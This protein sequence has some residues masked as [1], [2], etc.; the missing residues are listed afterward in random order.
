MSYRGS[1]SGTWRLN[2]SVSTWYLALILQIKVIFSAHEPQILKS[3]WLLEARVVGCVTSAISQRG[4][5]RGCI[6]YMCTVL[7][8]RMP[9]KPCNN[10]LAYQGSRARN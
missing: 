3:F 4:V 2:T 8:T 9:T 10:R 7:S 6:R 5:P 1:R